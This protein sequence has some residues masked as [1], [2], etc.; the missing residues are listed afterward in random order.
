MRRRPH[1]AAAGRP[2][3][4]G[5]KRVDSQ[6]ELCFTTHAYK[7][8]PIGGARPVSQFGKD[9]LQTRRS[10]DVG[11]QTYHYYSLAAASA[12]GLGDV[13]ELAVLA[14]G[15]AGE[16]AALGGRPDGHRGRRQGG[17]RLARPAHLGPRNRLPAGARADAGLHRRS[18]GRRPRGDARRHGGRGRRSG[19][20]QSA[21]SGRSGDRSLGDGRC[22]RQRRRLRRERRVSSSSAIASATSSCA[23]DRSPSTTFGWFRR[24]PAS[25]TRSISNT[26]RRSSGPAQD[27]GAPSPIRTRSSAPTATR[28]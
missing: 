15:V 10:L 19:E 23:G 3:P 20:D 21:G 17:G 12:A 24:E 25:V 5:W 4:S 9:T 16:P 26:S 1:E 2:L 14:Q 11:G 7:M 8:I 27:D 13:S 22:I 18:G 6:L 28:R